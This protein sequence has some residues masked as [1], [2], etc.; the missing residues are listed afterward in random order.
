MLTL[1][2]IRNYLNPD[3]EIDILFNC[4]PKLSDNLNYFNF[5]KLKYLLLE[6]PSFDIVSLYVSDLTGSFK[7][8]WTMSLMLLMVGLGFFVVVFRMGTIHGM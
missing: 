8:R 4:R 3:E 1:A 5:I 2:E 7:N 6:L